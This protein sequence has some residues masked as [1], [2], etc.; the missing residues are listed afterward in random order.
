M[1]WGLHADAWAAI[2][3]W[4]T[5]V[6]LSATAAIALWQVRQARSLQEE[7]ARPVVVVDLD[8]DRHPKIIHLTFENYGRTS[9]HDVK[10]TFEP[11][12][13][14]TI[15][16]GDFVGFFSN[17]FPTLAP[18]KRIVGVFDSSVQRLPRTDLPKRYNA[19]AVYF[20]RR[21]RRFE[22]KFV[23]DLSVY[24]GRMSVTEKD[25]GD[26][27]DTLKAIADSLHGY[28]S[29]YG[30]IS[31]VTTSEQNAAAVAVERTKESRR[32]HDALSARLYP[33]TDTPG[34]TK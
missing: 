8:I 14:T 15:A 26:V 4:A 21:R 6:V 9:A 27:V 33:K 25:I 22:D 2:A 31:V 10:V 29:P 16:D 24:E 13:T 5:L 3:S 18:G 7:E 30:G 19:T 17:T 34:A 23:L 20:D 1:W 12:L 28:E 11:S 32:Q